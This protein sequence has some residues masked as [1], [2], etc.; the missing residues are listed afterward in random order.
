VTV[1]KPL[2]VVVVTYNSQ[3]HI[4]SLASSLTDAL[5]G[6]W[7]WQ[8]VVVDNDSRDGTPQLCRTLLPEARVI[9]L[10]RNVGYA[11]GINAG[12]REMEASGPVLVLNP[13]VRLHPGSVTLLL[14]ALNKERVGIAVPRLCT[15][16]GSTSFSL[17]RE[18]SIG[19]VWAEAVLGGHRAAGLGKSEVIAESARYEAEQDVDWATGAVMAISADCRA[20]IGD[21]DESFFLYSEEV[22]YCRRA[23]TAGF[24]IRYEPAAVAEHAG[25]EYGTNVALWRTLVRNRARDYRRH[26]GALSSL[27]FQAGLVVNELLRAPRSSAHRAGLRAALQPGKATPS[28]SVRRPGESNGF[29][30]F[31]AQDWWYHNQAHSD[32]QLMREVARTQPVLVVNSLGLRFPRRGSSSNPARRV[33]RKVRSIA[34]FVRRPLSDNPHYHVMSPVML[35]FYGDSSRARLN[36]WLIR[37]QVRLAARAIGIGRRPSIGITIPSAW[38]VARSMAR[39]VLLYNRSDLHSAFP[40]ADNAWV[41]SL[42]NQLLEH[43]DR[44]LYVSHELMRMD[45]NRVDGREYFLDHG[46]DLDHFTPGAQHDAAQE[47]TSI[48]PPRAGFFGGLDDYVVD[49]D[50][51]RRTALELP[52][53][54]LVLIGDASVPMDSLTALPN[55][56]WLGYRPYESIPALGRGFDVGL[57][58]W[59]DNEW[60]QFA[61]PIK[62]KE[63]LA[64]GLPVVTTEYPEVEDYRGRVWVAQSREE[65]PRLV[66]KAIE[67]PGD[68]AQRRESV[69]DCSWQARAAQLIDIADEARRA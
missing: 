41:L 28:G 11:A 43:S 46:V 53:V 16:D 24:K 61:N 12:M 7:S 3:A 36:A 6:V 55:V 23:R 20:A 51:L 38:P 44:V 10:D 18:P 31:A 2:T 68:P 1:P 9:E 39:S 63:Y 32:F 8:L 49:L 47:M 26:H 42:E 67:N 30:W 21:W 34:K 17:R 60:I 5:S 66:R 14:Q 35:P 33:L 54:S 48:P 56:H 50:L 69:L 27:A 25:G 57:M 29:I 19:R 37:Q 40:E 13:D 65:F 52:D 4:A 22:D 15:S 62:L 45:R 58:P 59:L 64:L